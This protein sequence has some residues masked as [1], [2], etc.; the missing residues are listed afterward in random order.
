MVWDSEVLSP[1]R[2]GAPLLPRA[3]PHVA[4]V[5]QSLKTN[6]EFRSRRFIALQS[7]DCRQKWS[8][9]ILPKYHW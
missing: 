6:F 3:L 5:I 7:K 4:S 9:L 8:R 2:R 1:G